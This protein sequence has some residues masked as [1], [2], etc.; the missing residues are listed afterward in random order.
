MEEDN[1]GI[2]ADVGWPLN[3]AMLA[4]QDGRFE[5]CVDVLY[6]VKYKVW[7]IGG[8][9]AQVRLSFIMMMMVVMMMVIGVLRLRQHWFVLYGRQKRSPGSGL[10]PA[11]FDRSQGVFTLHASTDSHAQPRPF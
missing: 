3:Q 6:P 7:R 9:N 5:E 11:L 10:S 1:H 8:S 4:Y 2:T